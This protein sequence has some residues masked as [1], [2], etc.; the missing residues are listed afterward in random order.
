[1]ALTLGLTLNPCPRTL[2]IAHLGLES[3]A[4]GLGEG[5]LGTGCSSAEWAAGEGRKPSAGFQSLLQHVSVGPRTAR[6]HR[7][8]PGG[9]ACSLVT[10][11]VGHQEAP[12]AASPAE[13]L[14]Q[15]CPQVWL[16]FEPVWEGTRDTRPKAQE[17]PGWRSF[18][19][20][21]S[22]VVLGGSGQVT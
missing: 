16:P 17:V 6:G 10:G 15:N 22:I 4:A 5:H 9:L 19:P 13:P 20:S 14:D 21:G 11:P 12:L 1:M 7:P 3:E 8:F 2:G 18:L